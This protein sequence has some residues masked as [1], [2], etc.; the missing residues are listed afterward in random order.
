MQRMTIYEWIKK[1]EAEK[2]GEQA[3]DYRLYLIHDGETVFYVGQSQNPYNRFLAHMGLAGRNA[4]SE[5]GTFIRENAPASGDWTFE[6]YTLEDCSQVIEACR[7]VDDAEEALIKLYRPY[8][9]AA[10]NPDPVPLPARYKSSYRDFR[11]ATNAH[12]GKL[13]KLFNIK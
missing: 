7:N 8:F 4:P 3:E 1:V 5:V 11:E 13:S 12:A 6:Q 2:L 10:A 9:N